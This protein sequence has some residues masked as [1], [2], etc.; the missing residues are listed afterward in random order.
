M[1]A[2]YDSAPAD[3]VRYHLTRPSEVRAFLSHLDAALAVGNLGV[4]HR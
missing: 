2:L 1:R 4:P 3:K